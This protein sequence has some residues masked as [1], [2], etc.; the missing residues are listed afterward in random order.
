MASVNVAASR[1]YQRHG[2]A[3]AAM[4]KWQYRENINM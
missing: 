2:A 4:A 1:K 3:M